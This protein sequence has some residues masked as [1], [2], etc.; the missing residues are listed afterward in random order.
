M[1]NK[2]MNNNFSV[3]HLL[4]VFVRKDFRV[5]F[6][7]LAEDMGRNQ[8]GFL[9]QNAGWLEEDPDMVA[10]RLAPFD[11][12]LDSA[13][14]CGRHECHGGLERG[15]IE[16]R[17]HGARSIANKEV[18]PVGLFAPEVGQQHLV[19]D[20]LFDLTNAP[21]LKVVRAVHVCQACEE[22]HEEA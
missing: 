20:A 12:G 22:P 19:G 7:D 3:W 2:K 9:R 4:M 10:L 1:K 21:G 17:D 8:S 5:G 6:A 11:V 18:D 15:L 16:I 13:V 14:S